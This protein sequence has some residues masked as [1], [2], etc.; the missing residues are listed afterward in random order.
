MVANHVN[1]LHRV[2]GVTAYKGLKLDVMAPGHMEDVAR[3]ILT[4][5][6]TWRKQFWVYNNHCCINLSH[7]ICRNI[8][9]KE[10]ERK[11]SGS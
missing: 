2:H 11:N 7:H 10:C 9:V 8:N 4:I 3:T 5:R 1:G 6:C